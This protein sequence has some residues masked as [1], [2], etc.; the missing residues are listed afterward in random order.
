MIRP[1][2]LF[3]L[4][5]TTAAIAGP[6]GAMIYA[7]QCASCHAETRLGRHR[8]CADPRKPWPIK[9]RGA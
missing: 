7:D 1:I 2:V 6:N 3:S 8:P 4:L 9:G 5:A